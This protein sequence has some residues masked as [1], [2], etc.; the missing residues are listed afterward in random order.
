[1]II[2]LHTPTAV[3]FGAGRFAELGGHAARYGG[4]ALLVCGRT[5][6]RRHGLLAAASAELERAG[7][8][9][10]VSDNISPEPLAS[11]VDAAVGV[12][13]RARCDVVVALGGGSAIDAGKAVAVG[14]RVGPVGPLVGT[15]LPAVEDALPVIAVPTVTG[16]GA[17]V[18]KGAI[19]TDDDRA[20]KSGIRGDSLFPRVAII[21]PELTRT[22]PAPVV[23]ASAFDALTHAVEGYVARK[24]NPVTRAL[25]VRALDILGSRLPRLAAGADDPAL[26]ADLALAALLGG[27]NVANASTCLP[28]RLQ[29]AMGSVPRVTISHGRGLA[30][31]YPAWLRHAQPHAEGAFATVAQ[32]LGADDAVTAVTRLLDTTGVGA[33]L[34]SHGFRATDVD[35]LVGGVTG[36]TGNDPVPDIDVD[37]IRTLYQESL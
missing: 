9:V 29:Q 28:H 8:A 3:V 13:A 31:V 30:A 16:S 4:R 21:D 18:T 5:A 11:E 32:A 26:R 2:D 23:A 36:D 33:P 1:M 27:I 24:A 25:A 17:E 34:R 19:V 14:L 10:A 12:A 15:T 37:L 35:A 7:L 20:L 22:V 6:A